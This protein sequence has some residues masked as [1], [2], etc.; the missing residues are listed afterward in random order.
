LHGRAQAH[1]QGF[2]RAHA[3]RVSRQ[4]EFTAAHAPPAVP[5][6]PFQA[7]TSA[8]G[9][10]PRIGYELT[11]EG[12]EFFDAA[13]SHAGADTAEDDTFAVRFAFFARTEAD[14]RRLILEGRRHRLQERLDAARADTRRKREEFDA[15][16]AALA[17]HG[18]E[19]AEREVRWLSELI[20]AERRHPQDP[21]PQP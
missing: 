13:V 7:S 1:R 10:R 4:F 17:R 11:P 15:W 3:D 12:K 16:S 21:G 6:K 18:E 20:D 19:T 9:R 2:E 5:A 14:I 8:T